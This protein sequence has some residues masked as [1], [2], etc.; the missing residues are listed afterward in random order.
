MTSTLNAD[1]DVD[2]RERFL[3]GDKDALVDLEAELLGLEEVD[4]RAVDADDA[5]A[6]TGVRDRRS[7]L[8]NHESALFQ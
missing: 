6:L 1:A 2:T 5:L 7:S 8:Q 3:A 4:G